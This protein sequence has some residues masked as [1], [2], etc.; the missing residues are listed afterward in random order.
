MSEIPRIR[1]WN[2][3]AYVCFSARIVLCKKDASITRSAS[4]NLERLLLSSRPFKPFSSFLPLLSRCP[5]RFLKAIE[6]LSST[7]QFYQ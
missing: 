3:Y 2:E 7:F 4:I 6:H 5:S 1:Y